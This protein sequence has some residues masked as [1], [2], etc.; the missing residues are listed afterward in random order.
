[1]NVGDI[2]EGEV[3]CLMYYHGVQVDLGCQ[4]DGYALKMQLNVT[5]SMTYI[6]LSM[7]IFHLSFMY[8]Q[9]PCSICFPHDLQF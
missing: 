7:L 4:Y 8:P 5:K 6:R 9:P 1:M 2:L 3:T